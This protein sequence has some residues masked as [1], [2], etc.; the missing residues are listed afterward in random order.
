MTSKEYLEEIKRQ[1]RTVDPDADVVGPMAVTALLR[2]SALLSRQLAK[3]LE[4]EGIH[5]TGL[6]VLSTLAKN[7][8][9]EG[10]PLNRLAAMMGVTPASITNRIESLIQRKWIT[11]EASPVDRRVFFV[12]LTAEGAKFEQ[13]ASAKYLE[14]ESKLLKGLKKSDKKDLLKLLTKLL[15]D[16]ESGADKP[17]QDTTAP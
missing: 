8:P 3:H 4:A 10:M 6:E 5:P 1:R 16:I 14:A 15:E 13:T 2:L 9:V 12:R 11:R 7:D 17:D